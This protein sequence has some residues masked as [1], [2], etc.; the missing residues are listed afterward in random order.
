LAH[1]VSEQQRTGMQAYRAAIVRLLKLHEE[2]WE[3]ILN[4]ERERLGLPPK[5]RAEEIRRL[6][7]KI[8]NTRKS[9]ERFEAKL[10][11]LSNSSDPTG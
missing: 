4:E 11:E 5:G 10:D 2:D 7:D 1:I 6:R 3:G 9:L 8:E